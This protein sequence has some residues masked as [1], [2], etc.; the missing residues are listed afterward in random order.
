MA[1][2]RSRDEHYRVAEVDA[3]PKPHSPIPIMIGGGGQKILTLAVE[4]AD[5]VGIN[6]KIVGRKINPESMATT[7]AEA[8][9]EKLDVVRAA[10]GDKFDEL[11]LQVQIFKT[12]VTDQPEEA[13]EQLAP[14]FGLPPDVMLNAPFFQIGIGRADHREHPGDARALG[15]QLRVVPD[16]RDRADGARR[17]AARG[18]LTAAVRP[19]TRSVAPSGGRPSPRRQRVAGSRSGSP[20]GSGS[21]SGWS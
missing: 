18:D 20:G 1:R 12:V 21:R 10:A 7:A 9:D 6:P 5:I 17:V 3:V 16:R 13:A 8:M 4:E 15:D 11:E 2:S 14:A 19:V